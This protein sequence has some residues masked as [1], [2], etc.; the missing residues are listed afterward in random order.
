MGK[1][2]VISRIKEEGMTEDKLIA[3]QALRI[4]ELEEE[5]ENFK[6]RMK[7]IYG[8]IYCV[9]GPLNDNRDGYTPIQMKTFAEIADYI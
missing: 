8:L 7:S 6:E 5:N 2:A 9:G 4:A 3:K 1:G